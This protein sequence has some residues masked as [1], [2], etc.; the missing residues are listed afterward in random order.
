MP[1]Y[2]IGFMPVTLETMCARM[3][4]IANVFKDE[5]FMEREDTF[6]VFAY[7]DRND[8]CDE[9][10][11]VG[12]ML[13]S[14]CVEPGDMCIH[15]VFVDEGY[16][17]RGICRTFVKGITSKANRVMLYCGDT[18]LAMY[19]DKFDFEARDNPG[20]KDKD[21]KYIMFWRRDRSVPIE[22]L[23]ICTEDE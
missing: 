18:H 19:R 20:A 21:E 5:P 3:P 6:A 12:F 8:G 11:V 4:D 17:M 1:A 22:D 15:H 7:V 10:Q 2:Q 14:G 9:H 13:V 16:R 23:E